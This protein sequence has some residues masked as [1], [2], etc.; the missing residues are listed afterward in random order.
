[1][2]FLK[3][4]L[5]TVLLL[6]ALVT[7]LGIVLP[8][9][10]SVE[11]SLVIDACP[12]VVYD[13][14]AHFKNWEK[15]SPWAEKDSIIQSTYEGED[16][17]VG[18][19]HNWTGNPEISGVGK[20]TMTEM[21]PQEIKYDLEF[22]VP[23]ESKSKGYFKMEEAEGG[24]KVTW[25][26]EG[27][28]PF[29]MNIIAGIFMDI[30]AKIGVDFEKGLQNMSEV[31]AG[32]TGYD[33]EFR[34]S[35]KVDY[36][37]KRMQM[38]MKDLTASVYEETFGQIFASLGKNR[39]EVG[40]APM[41]LFHSFDEETL[42]M[43]MV[44]AVPTIGPSPVVDGMVI[45]S[46]EEGRDA[47]GVHAGSYDTSAETW[48]NMESYMKCSSSEMRG[49]P[50]EQYIVGPDTEPDTSKWVTHVVYPLAAIAD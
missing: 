34:E 10:Y 7:I 42:D 6:I 15:W 17:T 11:R 48:G 23:F 47:Y 29:P 24:V 20:M 21:N 3:G 13:E 19:V 5:I 30:D 44:I 8:K 49:M 46:I 38:N 26:D 32:Q 9:E 36:L 14:F 45:G 18:A 39:V 22:I 31:L 2:K 1:M 37:G 35:P 28:M 25:G 41:T 12:A 33:P 27:E 16:G 40:G 50:Y 4:L 43:D